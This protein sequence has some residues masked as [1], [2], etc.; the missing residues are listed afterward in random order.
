MIKALGSALAGS[1]R[2]LIV[3]SG[4][5]IANTVPG[6]VGQGRQRD[7]RF[8]RASPRRLGRGGRR[9]RSRGRQ[10]V[11]DAAAAGSRHGQAG[12]D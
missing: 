3:T 5:G 9:C 4:T 8:R 6:R 10:R 2:P 1:D 11:G 7:R 12:S